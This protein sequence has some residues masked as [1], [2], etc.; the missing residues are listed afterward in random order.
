MANMPCIMRETAQGA[1]RIALEDEQ[2]ARREIELLGTISRPAAMD[3]IRQLRCLAEQDADAPIRLLINSGGGEVIAGLAIYDT[4][5]ALPCDVETVCVGEA[6]SMAAIIFA[7]GAKGKRA[8][9]PNS[10]VLIHDPIM[11]DASGPALTVEALTKRL[12]D[13][14]IQIAEIISKHTGKSVE[15]VLAKTSKDTYFSAREA[16]DFGL[17]DRIIAGR[18]THAA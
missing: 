9:L 5:Q 11:M 15:E 8:I 17:A 4:I 18:D 3:I 1:Y 12:M 13:M 14:R 7:G 6:S 16:V 10:V 2:F